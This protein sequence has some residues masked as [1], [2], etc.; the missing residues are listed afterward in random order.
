MHSGVEEYWV[1]NYFNHEVTVYKFTD[2][3]FAEMKT[4]V[5]DDIVQSF[6]FDGFSADM[7]DIFE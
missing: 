4:F 3:K 6:L 7:K 2:R 5:K 1:I